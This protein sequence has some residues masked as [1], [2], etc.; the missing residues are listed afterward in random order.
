MQVNFTVLAGINA[1]QGPH[2]LGPACSHQPCYAEDLA[3]TQFEGDIVEQ[4]F[5][6]EVFDFQVVPYE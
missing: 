1:E 4:S 3:F 5:L 6:T 2:D